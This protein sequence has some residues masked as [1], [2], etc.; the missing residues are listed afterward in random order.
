M[1]SNF[2]GDDKQ[3]SFYTGFPDYATFKAVFMALQPT[4]ENMVGWSQAQRL[5]H[6]N[7]EVIRQSF[8]SSKLST[9]DQFFLFLC[10]LRQGF[11]EQDLATRFHVSQPTVSRICVT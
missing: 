5:K 4:A 3:V 1:V 11:S 7:I 8:S 2:Q 10:R 9:M 6:T